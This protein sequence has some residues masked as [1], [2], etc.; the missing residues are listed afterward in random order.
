MRCEFVQIAC[1]A[2]PKIL[3]DLLSI[4]QQ[5]VAENAFVTTDDDLA[6]VRSSQSM[7]FQPIW[8]TD[9]TVTKPIA[10]SLR[11]WMHEHQMGDDDNAWAIDV[12]EATLIIWYGQNLSPNLQPDQ[13]QIADYVTFRDGPGR[14]DQQSQAGFFEQWKPAVTQRSR[15]LQSEID[16]AES[17]LAALQSEPDHDL[18]SDE[19]WQLQQ[20]LSE[21]RRVLEIYQTAPL[22]S[23]YM[24]P[25]I[26]ILANSLNWSTRDQVRER[27]VRAYERQIR[28]RLDEAERLLAIAGRSRNRS[29]S[30]E[31]SHCE[32]LVDYQVLGLGFT[33]IS[34]KRHKGRQTVRDAVKQMAAL[35]G[36]PLR[37]PSRG[38]SPPGTRTRRKPLLTIEEFPPRPE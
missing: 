16:E 15:A 33:A 7:R 25:A 27:Y 34:G 9:L 1:G 14:W 12:G 30:D 8:A 29:R 10:E 31:T 38:G 20:T 6:C 21:K 11:A 19:I 3:G 26:E 35:I 28:I 37:P 5:A 36:L 4:Y 24:I 22:D 2:K 32:W 18:R 13:Y 23:T 17:S